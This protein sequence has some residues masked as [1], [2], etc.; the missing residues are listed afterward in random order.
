M[1]DVATLDRAA[2]CPALDRLGQDD[3]RNRLVLHRRGECGVNLA[4]VMPA[5]LQVSE[6]V[7][8]EVLDHL[9][10]ARVGSEEVFPDVGTG[11]DDVLLELSVERLVHLMDEDP[12]CV[13]REKVVPFTTPDDL[14]DVPARTSEDRFEFLDDLA[15]TAH[16]A[17]EPLQVAVDYE[18]E[19]VEPL[20]RSETQSSHRFRLVHLAV[21][22]E[23]PHALPRSVLDPPVL[24]VTV[25][26]GLV[27]RIQRA[28]PHRH[29]GELPELRHEARMRIGRKTLAP[30][31]AT[32][33]VELL[34]VDPAL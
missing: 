10:E 24:E 3:G 17:V 13:A 30:G 21:A 1:G 18:D 8:R 22:Q 28:E 33:V 9:L 26:P 14:D 4:V 12:V 31:L 15:V 6:V 27:D 5:P 32:E 34:L 2:Q 19:V 7:I 23:R 11:L 20:P 29:G 25:E 16:R